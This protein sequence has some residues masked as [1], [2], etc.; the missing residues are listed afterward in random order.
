MPREHELGS[1]QCWCEP[2]LTQT[3]PICDGDDEDCGH[4]DES[5]L[6]PAYDTTQPMIIVHEDDNA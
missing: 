3:C 1:R 6:V 2:R 5:G 4:C